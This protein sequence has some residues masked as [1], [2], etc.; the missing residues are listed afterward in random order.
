M[1]QVRKLLANLAHLV[2]VF[3]LRN[4]RRGVGVLQPH[5]QRFIAERREQ[6]LRNC[7]RLQDAEKSDVQL[8]HAVHKQ[9]DAFAGLDAQIAEKLRHRVG[10]NPQV[11]EGE[12]LLIALVVFPVE[13][14]LVCHSQTADAVAAHP[15]NVDG[16]AG[17]VAQLPLRD[18]PVE[19]GGKFLIRFRCQFFA[20]CRVAHTVSDAGS[21]R[22]RT[23]E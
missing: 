7:A 2:K 15:A 13:R 5:E 9:A 22:L 21:F 23:P 18:G 19:V 20:D 6:R 14:H 4:D 8:G 12:P 3:L 16:I 1:P 10:Q 11:I 17:L